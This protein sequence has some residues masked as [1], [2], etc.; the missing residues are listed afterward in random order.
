MEYSTLIDAVLMSGPITLSI[1]ISLLFL[2]VL[3]WAVIMAKAIQFKKEQGADSKFLGQFHK[4]KNIKD[5]NK[6]A[7]YDEKMQNKGFAFICRE[8]HLELERIENNIQNLNFHESKMQ[9]NKSNVE[10]IVSR[11]LER[12]KT[13]E[14]TRLDK[15]ISI[16][17][18]TSN[19]AP[20]IGLLGTVVGIINAFS[21]IGKAGS[22]DLAFV[23]PAISEALVATALGLFVAIP[24]SIAFNYFKGRAQLL[25]EGHD[26]F[27]LMLLNKIQ[28]Y[29]FFRKIEKK[30]E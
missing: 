13:M 10:E 2:S 16:L 23:A 19:V 4:S 29:Y 26:M 15:S 24:S 7:T 1:F 17:A 6:N 9:I 22:A 30:A 3:I 18:T 28:Q 5:L 8:T 11:T 21:E 20:F 25:K 12:V 14:Q 27:A